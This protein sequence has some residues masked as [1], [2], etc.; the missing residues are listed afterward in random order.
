MLFRFAAVAAGLLGLAAAVPT[1]LDARD[2]PSGHEVEIQSVTYSGSG[3][4]PGSAVSVIDDS[5]TIVTIGYSQFVAQ[6]GPGISPAQNRRNCN[7]NIKL[8]YPSGWQYSIF[9][10]DF[11]G[12]ANIHKGDR[13]ECKATYWFSGQT[14][15]VS[16]KFQG[17]YT[18]KEQRKADT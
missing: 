7:L 14:Q 13:G 11:R 1:A 2:G 4:P 18:M 10:T 16:F 17:A 8:K 5:R 3:C 12:Y 9:D 15:Q 6:S